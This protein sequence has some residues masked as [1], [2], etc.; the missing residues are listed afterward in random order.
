MPVSADV[1]HW[2]LLSL[3]HSLNAEYSMT[4]TPLGI[5]TDTKLEHSPNPQILVNVDGRSTAVRF[6]L[7][8]NVPL[9]KLEADRVAGNLYVDA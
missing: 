4:L 8:E 5:D 1:L 9:P 2:T 3:L 7:Q 6:P